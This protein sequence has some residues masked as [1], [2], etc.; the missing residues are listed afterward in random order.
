MYIQG[1]IPAQTTTENVTKPRYLVIIYMWI[2]SHQIDYTDMDKDS[3][4][5]LY[6]IAFSFILRLYSVKNIIFFL[7][8]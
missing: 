6:F 5:L 2:Y 1:I 3:I 7:V 8:I 4:K